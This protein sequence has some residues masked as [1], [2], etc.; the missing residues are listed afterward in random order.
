MLGSGAARM[1]TVASHTLAQAAPNL[2]RLAKA[3]G[4]GAAGM[5]TV[6]SHTFAQA[7]PNLEHFTKAKGAGARMWSV[8]NRVPSIDAES[9]SGTSLD[10]VKGELELKDVT[11]A[12]P[13][14]P[15]LTVFN[16]FSLVV[17]AGLQCPIGPI[18]L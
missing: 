13:A 15:D 14:R 3:K 7:A 16:S 4:A 6:A 17:P 1:L 9:E 8:I 5:L 10:L 12:Y 18:P 11:F 2:E